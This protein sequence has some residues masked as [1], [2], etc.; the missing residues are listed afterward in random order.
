MVKGSIGETYPVLTAI[1]HFTLLFCA[2]FYLLWYVCP[3]CRAAAKNITTGW[4]SLIVVNVVFMI[5][6][7]LSSVYPTRLT[8]FSDPSVIPF[9]FL[10]I[11]IMAVYPVIFRSINSMSEAAMKREVETQNQL[12]VAQ[13]EAETA[14][15]IADSQ[16]RHDRRHHNLVMLEFAKNND[17]ES[18]REYLIQ[19]MKSDSEVWGEVRHCENTTVNTVLAVYERRARE[20]GIS[21][22][23]SALVSGEIDVLPQDLVIVIANLFENAINATSKPK[24]KNQHIDINIKD[25]AQRLLIKVENPCRANLTFDE[26]LY[27]IGIRSVISTTHKYE[28]MYDF[29]AENGIFSAKISLNLM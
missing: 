20:N 7:I 1:I 18:L 13:I 4:V 2:D 21:V 10:S 24:I 19:L 14:Q 3:L 16:S 23:I 28:G 11:S 29:T 5:T 6:I 27:G 12:L 22:H 26:T 17:I 15:I 8:G 9:V 25:S